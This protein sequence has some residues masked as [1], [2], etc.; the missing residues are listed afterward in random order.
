MYHLSTYLS[1]LLYDKMKLVCLYIFFRWYCTYDYI[2]KRTFIIRTGNLAVIVSLTAKLE[3]STCSITLINTF[4]HV[5]THTNIINLAKHLNNKHDLFAIH[6]FPFAIIYIQHQERA[7]L[8]V[9]VYM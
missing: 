6:M 1:V 3:I 4:Q 8:L 5:C 9:F 2:T 7:R